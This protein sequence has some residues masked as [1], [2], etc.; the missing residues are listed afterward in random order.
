MGRG[1]K[2]TGTGWHGNT[3]VGVGTYPSHNVTGLNTASDDS[4]DQKAAS[5]TEIAPKELN[6]Y[7]R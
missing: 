3:K 7:Y 6:E 4:V 2:F 5:E 1:I